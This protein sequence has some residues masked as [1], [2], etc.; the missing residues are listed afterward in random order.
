MMLSTIT[1]INLF[2]I[3]A[4][5]LYVAIKN[6]RRERIVA[7]LPPGPKA[8]PIIGNRSDLP[9]KGAR[10]WQHWLKHKEVYGPISS[11]TVFGQTL[12]IINDFRM[13]IELMEKRSALHSSRPP[14]VFCNDMVGWEYGFAMLAYSDRLRTYRKNAHGVIGSKWVIS[15]FH[16]LQD[17][18]ARRN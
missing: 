7:P 2:L 3:A 9:P 6:L 14:M 10:E 18:E 4:G 1:L 5:I 8:K 17:V 13:A 12:V 16:D 11:V 15:Q